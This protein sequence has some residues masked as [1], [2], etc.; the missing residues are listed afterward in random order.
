MAPIWEI[1]TC[2]VERI[3]S[4][5]PF[6]EERLVALSLLDATTANFSF[7]SALWLLERPADKLSDDVFSSPC[8]LRDAL[9]AVLDV[10]P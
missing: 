5:T 8:H 2:P 9:G 4:E 6:Q 7:T 3:F 10:Y 1:K